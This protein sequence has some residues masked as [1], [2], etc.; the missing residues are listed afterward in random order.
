VHQVRERPETPR[1]GAWQER[2][3]HPLTTPIPLPPGQAPYITAPML[4]SGAWP[5][6]VDFTTLPPGRQQTPGANYAAVTNVAAEATTECDACCNQP[7][8]ATA[9]TEEFHGPGDGGNR[10]TVQAGS[11]LCRIILQRFAIQQ[12]TAVQVSPNV[13]PRQWT[14][15][16]AGY[17]EPEYAPIGLY[18]SQAASAAG[19]G[20]Q[21][22]LIA[23]G[24]VGRQ[25]NG[26][27]IQVSY[28]HGWPH[29]ALTAAAVIGATTLTVD[30]C[31]GWAPITAGGFG[32]AGVLYDGALQEPNNVLSATATAGPG[33][34]MLTSPLQNAHEPGV[35]FSSLPQDVI[36]ASALFAGAAALVRGASAT[37][38][39]DTPGRGSGS[40][41]GSSGLHKAA[42]AK[43]GP[44]RRI[45]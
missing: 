43:L 5:V 32:A 34:L 16:P 23:Q 1:G 19:Q 31:T 29:T 39:R 10:V 27:V 21:A 22:V 11:G 25:R 12:V 18:G 17:Y 26:W 42:V 20:G 45:I 13:F 3:R 40:D 7:L 37:T 15:L 28:L 2:G 8:R 35:A 6:G 38:I 4:T 41:G 36:W 24:Y 44:Y 33:T 30:D 14:V 9:V